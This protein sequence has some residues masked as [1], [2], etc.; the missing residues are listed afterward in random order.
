[1]TTNANE[2]LTRA[3][4]AWR[5]FGTV[6]YVRARV[7]CETHQR[8]LLLVLG[9]LL[10]ADAQT[11]FAEAAGFDNSKKFKKVCGNAVQL[12]EGPFGAMMTA[13]AG[14]G[15]I[16]ASA[17]GGFK[18]AWACLVVAVGGFILRA[19]IGVFFEDCTQGG[20]GGN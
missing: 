17:M 9:I 14:I 19:Y 13:I 5:H 15:A 8:M 1:M 12:A 20:G 18:M 6:S 3:G 2:L 4:D 16:I 7:W 10:I 11:Q